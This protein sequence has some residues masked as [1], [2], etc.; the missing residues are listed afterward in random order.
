MKIRKPIEKS[1]YDEYDMTQ[2]EV[3]DVLGMSR[4]HVGS[5]ETRAKQKLKAALEKR[6]FKLTDLL[7][8]E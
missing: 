2:Q 8:R 1:S 3:A 7:W 5:L 4:A 6:G